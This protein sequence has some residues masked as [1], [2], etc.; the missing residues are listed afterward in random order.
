MTSVPLFGGAPGTR[1]Q[2]FLLVRR[3]L[4]VS[5]DVAYGF[6]ALFIIVTDC[7]LLDQH[8]E[9]PALKRTVDGPGGL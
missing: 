9:R 6:E 1:R 2:Y 3:G 7:A 5:D 4:L 8:A